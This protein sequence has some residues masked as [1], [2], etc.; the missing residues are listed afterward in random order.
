[1]I[2]SQA[3]TITAYARKAAII[4]TPEWFETE[5]QKLAREGKTELRCH[6]EYIIP[7]KA[8]LEVAGFDVHIEEHNSYVSWE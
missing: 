1:M 5:I 3:R 7:Q 2:V 4:G 6:R 8:A